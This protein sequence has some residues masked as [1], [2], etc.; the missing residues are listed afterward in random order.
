MGCVISLPSGVG[1]QQNLTTDRFV[2]NEI[3]IEPTN[4]SRLNFTTANPF[5]PGTL[6]VYL[7][8]RKLDPSDYSEGGNVQSFSVTLNPNNRNGLNS[9][10]SSS[11]IITIDYIKSETIL[12]ACVKNLY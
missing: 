7:D 4:C 8:G 6:R 11:E 9:P 10:P 12:M 2:F 5:V 1:C 3:P